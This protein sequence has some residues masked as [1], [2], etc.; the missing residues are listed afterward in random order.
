MTYIGNRFG[1][2]SY[3]LRMALAIVAGVAPLLVLM[4]V[5]RMHLTRTLSFE[6]EVGRLNSIGQL[7]ANEH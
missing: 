6:Q 2:L 5:N 4:T 1:Q 3:R 7:V